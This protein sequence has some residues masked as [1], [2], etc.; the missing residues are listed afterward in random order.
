[1]R[2]L[3]LAATLALAPWIA[4]VGQGVPRSTRAPRGPAC[5]GDTVTAIAIRAHL[6]SATDLAGE[7]RDAASRVLG[8][9]RGATRHALI[10]AYLRVAVGKVCSE[11]DRRES[12]RLLRAQPFIAAAAVRALPGTPGHTRVEVDVIDEVRPIVAAGVSRG[13][14]SSLLVG[15]QSLSGSGLSLVAHATRGFAYRDGYGLR[16]VQYGVFGRAAFAAVTAEQRA[17]DG[18]TVAIEL[19]E[20][21]LTD[22]QRRAFH[23]SASL[24]SGYVGLVRPTG[25]DVAMFVR[26][27]F[28]DIGWVTRIR[29]ASGRGT[30]ALVG[31]ALFGEDVRTGSD[32][33]IVSDTGLVAV[34]SPTPSVPYPAFAN[35]RVAAIGGV[36]ALRFTTV[37]GFDALTAAQDMGIGVQFDLLLGSGALTPAH[38][39]DVFIATDLY[40]GAGD[41]RSFIVA[42]VLAE[43]RGVNETHRWDG[44][45]ASARLAWYANASGVRA[46][47][48][49]VELSGLQHLVFPAQLSFRDADGGLPGF[50]GTAHAGGQR[51][52]LRVEERRLIH[53]FGTKADFAV[54]IFAAAGKLWAGDVPYGRTTPLHAAA[55]LSL[56]G[57]YPPSG[58]R[59]YRI[60]LAF[61]VNPE[62]GASRL[63]LRVSASDRTRLLW[64]EPSDV[65]RARTGAVPASL[66][67]W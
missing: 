56:L 62:R 66:M 59:T 3:R 53:S 52:I 17:V 38:A 11:V 23:A 5:D 10:H 1:M 57:A 15:T 20:P 24:S 49:S 28:Y 46:H 13:T 27:T 32:V 58:K 39:R 65:A 18:Q 16:A 47:N 21:Y 25:A 6:P 33:V 8:L 51:M 44:V 50:G 37:Q 12:E 22:L 67:K 35:T 61:P 34:P 60:D 45:V 54:A 40:A 7:T 26:R 30:I 19:A 2:S 55:G 31:A 63:E 4:A 14:L 64:R 48:A 9:P 36:R 29:R 42:R 43:A 41:E